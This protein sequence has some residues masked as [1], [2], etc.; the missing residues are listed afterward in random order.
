M[1]LDQ[2]KKEILRSQYEELLSKAK[3]AKNNGDYDSAAKCYDKAANR[4][5]AL[6]DEVESE[7]YTDKISKLNRLAET[8]R[9]GNEPSES[10]TN[11]G[12]NSAD[13]SKSNN[14]NTTENEG[15][16]Q[17]R[18]E[19]FITET[20][21]TWDDIGGLNAIQ[22]QIKGAI[23]LGAVS[24]KPA[25]VSATDRVLLFGPPGTGKTLL[26]SAIAGSLDA[27]F[28]DV[29]LGGLLSKYFGDSS[30][31]INVLFDLAGEMS[32]SVIFLDEIDALTQSRDSNSNSSS[33]RVLNTLLSELDGIDKGD[34]NFVMVIGATNQPGDLD[35]AV[36]R[37]FP[38]RLLIPLP[39]EEAAEEI[40][41]I[42]TVEGDVEFAN[43]RPESFIPAQ[44]TITPADSIPRTIARVAVA[45]N[46]S[47]SDL[48][49]LCQTAVDD[50]I[51]QSNPN[52]VSLADEGFDELAEFDL[53]VDS[54]T[55]GNVQS[56]FE[57]T[58]AS[59]SEPEIEGYHDWDK[60][61]GTTGTN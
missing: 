60:D 26:A 6:D 7:D 38:E 58:S 44:S 35:N 4:L 15:E 11:S 25:A 47:G 32:P 55:P 28:F 40:V 18:I 8:A 50:M 46:Y 41:R 30:K 29:K 45:R 39:D 53:S 27:T 17:D 3:E 33:R 20:N 10:A 12:R 23:A 59:L 19:S 31:L 43:Q 42:H 48:Q 57:T 24:N 52:L 36:R 34:N 61:Y 56:A 16:F 9:S 2:Y 13:P 37:R 54:I 21:V 1:S 5:S 51:R 49:A 22:D 14:S